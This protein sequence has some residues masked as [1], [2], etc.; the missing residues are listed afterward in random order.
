MKSLTTTIIAATLLLSACKHQPAV[1]LPAPEPCDQALEDIATAPHAKAAQESIRSY[2]RCEIA[3]DKID[4]ALEASVSR[5]L[6]RNPYPATGREDLHA[7]FFDTALIKSLPARPAEMKPA[8][9]RLED[10][11]LARLAMGD[12]D[13]ARAA[14]ARADRLR[15]LLEVLE[16]VAG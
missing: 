11:A 14:R 2:L 1:A 3:Q 5:Q 8:I 15:Q 10:Q 12:D 9:Q 7:W 6:R 13:M 16:D 4:P